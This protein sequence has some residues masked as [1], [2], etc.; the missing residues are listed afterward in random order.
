MEQIEKKKRIVWID[1]LNI[2]ACMGVVLLHSTNT[3]LH[4]FKGEIS[5]NWCLGLFTHSFFLWPVDVFFMLSGYTLIHKS[6]LV[7]GGVKRFYHR[8]LQRLLIPVI[9]WNVIYMCYS[10]LHSWKMSSKLD[11]PIEMLDKFCSFEYNANMW[12]FVPLICIYISLPF[13]A[14]FILNARR[15]VLKSYL[16]IS[17]IFSFMPPLEADFTVRANFQ[18]IFIFG[19]R[20]MVYPIAG[21]YFGNYEISYQMRKKM[22]LLS[23]LCI[24]IM[25]VGTIFLTLTNP[26]HYKYFIQYTNIPCTIIAYSVFIYFKH[27]DWEPLLK[28][29]KINQQKLAYLS[30][31]SL[32]I[33]LV[34]KIGFNLISHIPVIKNNM[35]ITFLIMYL[36][37]M[38]VVGIFKQIPLI[39]K[40]I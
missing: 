18:D 38:S 28:R 25:T 34:Q 39:R 22:Y 21:Y 19:S 14:V 11:A 40:I 8:R 27:V 16:I 10:L 30:S 12:F 2:I 5:L 36:G 3:E 15:E 31:L 26:V 13:L 24:I 23:F 17:M 4:N 29:I 37:C 33:Y 1:I 32:G 6:L 20:F 9:A 7:S 35:I